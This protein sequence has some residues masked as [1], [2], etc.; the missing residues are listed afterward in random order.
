MLHE[1]LLHKKFIDILVLIENLGFIIN[2]GYIIS[3]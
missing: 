1:L 2:N 3:L